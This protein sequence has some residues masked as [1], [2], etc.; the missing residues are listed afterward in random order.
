VRSV[1]AV[2][3]ILAA[4]VSLSTAAEPDPLQA[5]SALR[6]VPPASAPDVSFQMLDGRPA[7]LDAFRGRPVL[8]TF[9]TT[10]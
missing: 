6:V 3:L 10:W 2:A 1:V 8:L 5:M 9:F 4:G 7:R